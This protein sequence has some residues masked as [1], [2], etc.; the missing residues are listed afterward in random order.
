MIYEKFSANI[1][2]DEALAISFFRIVIINLFSSVSLCN[3]SLIKNERQ[4]SVLVLSLFVLKLS[5][6]FNI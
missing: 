2:D 3:K 5:Q 6:Q 4:L 1:I